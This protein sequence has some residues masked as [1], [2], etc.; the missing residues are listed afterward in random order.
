MLSLRVRAFALLTLVIITITVMV[1]INDGPTVK[2]TS[3]R[4]I[5]RWQVIS[6]GL[7]LRIS[8]LLW[9]M[10]C[11]SM[12]NRVISHTCHR[13][14]QQ[15]SACAVESVNVGGVACDSFSHLMNANEQCDMPNVC[16]R[17]TLDYKT[18]IWLNRQRNF[19][20]RRLWH[21]IEWSEIN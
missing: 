10:D 13:Y 16:V 2:N 12:A 1:D 20:K 15:C 5:C 9:W 14:T 7:L 3:A 18:A 21:K 8:T 4:P 19:I 6:S 17:V 11:M